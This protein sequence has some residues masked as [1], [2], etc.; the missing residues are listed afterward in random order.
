MQGVVAGIG[1]GV[2]GVVGL[3]IG[4]GLGSSWKSDKWQEIPV[5]Q[6]RRDLH[7]GASY[8]LGVSLRF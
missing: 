5:V 4:A 6:L 3:L 7:A 2:G 8:M 1:A